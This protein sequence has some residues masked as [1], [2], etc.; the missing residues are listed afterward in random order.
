MTGVISTG[1]N[2]PCFVVTT[3]LDG[4]KVDSHGVVLGA[5][6]AHFCFVPF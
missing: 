5:G 3:T 4:R 6:G 2:T 1:P